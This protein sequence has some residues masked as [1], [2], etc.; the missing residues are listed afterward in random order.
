MDKMWTEP[1]TGDMTKPKAPHASDDF[2][3]I[4]IDASVISEMG[5]SYNLTVR[6]IAQNRAVIIEHAMGNAFVDIANR[7]LAYRSRALEAGLIDQDTVT[8]LEG[9]PT[10]AK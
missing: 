9:M 8:A 5:Y 4:R 3:M 2:D 7:A 1:A 6:E 10:D